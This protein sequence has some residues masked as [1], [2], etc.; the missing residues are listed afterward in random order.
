MF[1]WMQ[2]RVVQRS[3][4]PSPVVHELEVVGQLLRAA[5][6]GITFEDALAY[7]VLSIASSAGSY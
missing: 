6:G 5:G 7:A 1:S 3:F 4:A 2:F